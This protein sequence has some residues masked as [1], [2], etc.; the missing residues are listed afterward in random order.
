MNVWRLV[1]RFAIALLAFQATACSG[2]D[3]DDAVNARQGV[4]NTLNWTARTE[5][6]VYGYLVYRSEDRAGPYRRVEL[7]VVRVPADGLDRHA[8]SFVD[9]QVVPGVTYYYY[10]DAVSDSGLKQRFS[11]IISRTTAEAS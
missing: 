3:S 2:P 6:G 4:S 1:G 7:S 5:A 8:Y 9:R 10:L 11:G